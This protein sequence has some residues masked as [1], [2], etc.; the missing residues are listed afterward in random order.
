MDPDQKF[1]WMTAT[2]ALEDGK[3]GG[4][5]HPQIQAWAPWRTM[6]RRNETVG[7]REVAKRMEAGANGGYYGAE[8]S[9]GASREGTISWE[10]TYFDEAHSTEV[11][12]DGKPNGVRW[13]VK[14]NKLQD[15]GVTPEVWVS[16]L[17]SRSSPA[18][19][20]VNF[21][22]YAHA[23]KLSE[24]A[25]NTKRFF[26]LEPGRTK[27]FSI[28]PGKKQIITRE[29]QYIIKAI[30]V[31]DFGKLRDNELTSSLNVAWGLPYQQ[32][33]A[34]LSDAE[35]KAEK[36]PNPAQSSKDW[37]AEPTGRDETPSEKVAQ[38]WAVPAAADT[39]EYTRLVSLEGRVANTEA[40]IAAQ[41]QFILQLQRELMTK[42][43]Q[44]AK[45]ERAIHQLETLRS[46]RAT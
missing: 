24:F 6:D 20:L 33:P 5:N 11:S 42:D 34:P 15:Q 9:L 18:P 46:D 1:Q 28:T 41:D 25:Y 45:M 21:H 40:R 29:G 26:G 31:A 27:T 14:Q 16:A 13:F 23:G 19:Y 43:A 30:D 22:I 17:F 4:E 35:T 12:K 36:P 37:A 10:Q 39:A 44:L 8:M 38:T 2:L 7:H 32:T 3:G